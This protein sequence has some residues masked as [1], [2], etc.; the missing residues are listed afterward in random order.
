MLNLPSNPKNKTLIVTL[1]RELK[2][3]KEPDTFF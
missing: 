1:D 3:T 2:N